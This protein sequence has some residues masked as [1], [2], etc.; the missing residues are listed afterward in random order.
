MMASHVNDGLILNQKTC[1]KNNGTRFL[2]IMAWKTTIAEI[3]LDKKKQ[4]FVSLLNQE[5]VKKK[6]DFV[7]LFLNTIQFLNSL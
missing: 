5:K 7:Q 1:L 3:L 2:K 6:Q 4:F